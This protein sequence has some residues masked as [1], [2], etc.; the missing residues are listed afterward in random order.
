MPDEGEFVLAVLNSPAGLKVFI[1]ASWSWYSC[2]CW[3]MLPLVFRFG[4]LLVPHA[5]YSPWCWCVYGF[6]YVVC[7]LIWLLLFTQKKINELEKNK[8][9]PIKNKFFLLK[10]FFLLKFEEK[11]K[12]IFIKKFFDKQ[13]QKKIVLVCICGC[14]FVWKN[15]GVY[16]QFFFLRLRRLRKTCFVFVLF[17]SK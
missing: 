14:L 2:C 8:W 11:T 9:K 15:V 6:S 12:K 13:K 10:S 3:L 7:L 5:L 4:W 16:F 1:W 17:W